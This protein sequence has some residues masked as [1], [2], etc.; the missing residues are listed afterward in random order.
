MLSPASYN[1]ASGLVLVC[2]MTSAR[3]GYPFEIPAAIAG[4]E[5]AVLAD[6]VKSMDWQTR[7]AVFLEEA[8]ESLLHRT[9]AYLALLLGI[10]RAR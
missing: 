4:K 5:G 8:D 2:P 1:R 6:Q 7:R 9:R 10:P 3:K